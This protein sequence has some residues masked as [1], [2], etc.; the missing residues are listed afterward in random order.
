MNKFLSRL[1]I[2]EDDCSECIA[3][4]NY[5]DDKM[6][7][8]MQKHIECRTYYFSENWFLGTSYRTLIWKTIAAQNLT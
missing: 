4:L 8:L 3:S 5:K 2:I 7:S 1:T 6:T